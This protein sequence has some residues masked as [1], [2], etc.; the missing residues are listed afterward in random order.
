LKIIL[1]LQTFANL[2]LVFLD[3]LEVKF[4][5]EFVVKQN[6]PQKLSAQVFKQTDKIR[7]KQIKTNRKKK[8]GR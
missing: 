2:S 5:I 8:M 6:F 1:V 3:T 7:F 4:L